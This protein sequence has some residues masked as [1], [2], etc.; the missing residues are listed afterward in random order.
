MLDAAATEHLDALHLQTVV[1]TAANGRT[2]RSV[3]TQTVRSR[4]RWASMATLS[5]DRRVQL[6]AK[7]GTRYAFTAASGVAGRYRLAFADRPAGAAITFTFDAGT[8][9]RRR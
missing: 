3:A 8:G 2:S 6:V 9:S 4:R 7:D 1:I 5:R